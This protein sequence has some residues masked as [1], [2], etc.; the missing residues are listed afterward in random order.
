VIE[1]NYDNFGL[2]FGEWMKEDTIS[3]GIGQGVWLLKQ[4]V[5]W[6]CLILLEEVMNVILNLFEMKRG[7]RL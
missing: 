4:V 1:F 5:G 7:G 6:P 2:N 3:F